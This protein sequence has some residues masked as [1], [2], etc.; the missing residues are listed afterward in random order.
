MP[1]PPLL[2]DVTDPILVEPNDSPV[3]ISFHALSGHL[4]PETLRVTGSVN[5]HEVA[6][7][8]DGGSTNNFVQD[9]MVYILNLKAQPTKQLS[10]IVGKEMNSFVTRFS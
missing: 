2:E 8:I 5:G 10:V 3:Q 4:N 1:F 9:K 7:L 6:V